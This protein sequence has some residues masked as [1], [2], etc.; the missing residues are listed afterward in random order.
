MYS[1]NPLPHCRPPGLA[2]SLLKGADITHLSISSAAY[3]L[4]VKQEDF[5]AF[6]LKDFCLD[7]LSC[8]TFML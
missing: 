1:W 8:L 6:K 2:S 5:L 7:F 4:I 3:L